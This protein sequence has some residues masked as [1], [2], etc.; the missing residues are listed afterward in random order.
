VKIWILQIT[1]LI[2]ILILSA[3][4]KDEIKGEVLEGEKSVLVGEWV[5]KS[6][7]YFD[8]CEW[9]E[10]EYLTAEEQELDYRVRITKDGFIRFFQNG[11]VVEGGNIFFPGSGFETYFTGSVVD[12]KEFSFTI[13][14][15]GDKKRGFV[16]HGL[17]DSMNATIPRLNSTKCDVYSDRLRKVE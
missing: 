9:T 10:T 13:W 7:L 12:P 17:L 14:I 4:R 2:S 1:L 11:E 16:G 15:D 5:L 3:C 8:S 6:S